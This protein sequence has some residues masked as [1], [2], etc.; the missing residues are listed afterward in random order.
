MSTKCQSCKKAP[1]EIEEATDESEERYKVCRNCLHRLMTHSLRP[2]EWYNL[3]SIHGCWEPLLD[4]EYYNED[5]IAIRP[6]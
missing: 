2:G 3:A 5:G 1:F 6:Q 4:E